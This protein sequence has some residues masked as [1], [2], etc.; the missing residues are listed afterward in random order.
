MGKVYIVFIEH[1]C[2]SCCSRHPVLDLRVGVSNE[3]LAEA[4]LVGGCGVDV[5]GLCVV[6]C[7]YG[8][9]CVFAYVRTCQCVRLCDCVCMRAC[10]C[11]L[12][13]SVIVCMQACLN[14]HALKPKT[15]LRIVCERANSAS[16]RLLGE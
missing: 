10:F 13:P 15:N 6:V 12:Q 11:V 1:V 8:W 14:I 5:C 4:W 2:V 3:W 9:G 16:T 7:V